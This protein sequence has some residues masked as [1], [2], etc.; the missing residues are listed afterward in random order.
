MSKEVGVLLTVAG[1]SG[2]WESHRRQI[3]DYL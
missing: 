2:G 1:S 3:V